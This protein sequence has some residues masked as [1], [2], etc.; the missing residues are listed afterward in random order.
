MGGWGVGG[1]GGG[2]VGG[3]GGGSAAINWR[4]RRSCSLKAARQ[5]PP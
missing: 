1:V 3:W 2:G 4:V 5:Y